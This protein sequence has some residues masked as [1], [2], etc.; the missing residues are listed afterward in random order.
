M[1]G[2]FFYHAF[3]VALTGRITRPFCDVIESQAATAL[4]TIGGYGSSQVDDYRFRHIVSFRSART[5]VVGSKAD[6]GSLNTSV[7]VTV[8]G[9]NILN[10]IR[11]DVITARLASRHAVD[12]LQPMI[13]AVGT[14]FRGLTIGGN[15]VPATID[16]GLF[17][18]ELT[19]ADFK[20]NA[21][22]NARR[23]PWAE[24][25]DKDAVLCSVVQAQ[26]SS[27]P[28]APN[29]IQ[30]ASV[31][32]VFL[33]ELL[34]SPYARRLTMMRVVLGS[35]DAGC[36]EVGSGEVNGSTYP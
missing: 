30:V 15:P 18:Q 23:E 25:K 22:A 31:G 24:S 13:T 27:L 1:A 5:F 26:A 4:G 16:R 8:E 32:T 29:S 35:P 3:G 34:V 2:R 11:A 14:E 36:L 21:G 10:V 6:D 19:Y 9:L 7:T 20:K 33:G 17:G 12:S 28:Q